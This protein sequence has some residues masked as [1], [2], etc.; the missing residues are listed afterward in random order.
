MSENNTGRDREREKV[1]ERTKV[2]WETL[3]EREKRDEGE[4]G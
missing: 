1:K 2:R 4:S 3:G